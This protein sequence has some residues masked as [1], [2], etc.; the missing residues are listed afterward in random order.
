[1]QVLC[2]KSETNSKFLHLVKKNKKN[3]KQE[4][5][6]KIYTLALIV[7]GKVTKSLAL[8]LAHQA[9]WIE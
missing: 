3:A 9:F 8:S 1:M 5:V 7:P 2:I 4:R 6:K